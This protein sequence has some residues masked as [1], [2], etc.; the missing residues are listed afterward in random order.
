M[1]RVCVWKACECVCV[2]VEDVCA[3][4]VCPCALYS[5]V[6]RRSSVVNRFDS[7]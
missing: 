5:V 1:C 2:R 7:S 4:G 6:E 3:L